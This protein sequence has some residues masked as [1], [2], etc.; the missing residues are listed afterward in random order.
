MKHC[1]KIPLLI[2]VFFAMDLALVTAYFIDYLLGNPIWIL[3]RFFDLDRESSLPTWY[4]SVQWFS[5]AALLAI[6]ARHNFR[7]SQFK[8]WLLIMLPGVFLA[9]SLDEIAMLHE[10]IGM[11]IDSISRRDTH[12][13]VTGI[14]MFVI[15]VPFI[16]LFGVIILV[17]R[18]Y[19]R[20]APRI[21][22]A[23]ALGV[24][25][26]SNF[27]EPDSV[28]RIL[29]I[30]A[31]EFCEML[32]G[33]IVLWGSYESLRSEDMVQLSPISRHE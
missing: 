22:L 27:V 14:W 25:T 21:M 6:F 31:E 17:I 8:S 33:T 2:L 19:F 4:S 15:G 11:A 30:M 9:F 24:E 12:F 28:D 32:G 29:L 7:R 10:R 18:T 26:L 5:V 23:G 1:M 3:T 20:R 16:I 13:P